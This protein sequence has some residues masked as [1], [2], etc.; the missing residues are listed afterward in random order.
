MSLYKRGYFF[1]LIGIILLTL[2]IFVTVNLN[3]WVWGAIFI[4][5]LLLCTIGIILLIIHLY[6]QVKEDKQKNT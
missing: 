2:S 4:S 3:F 5:S 6:R 1:L